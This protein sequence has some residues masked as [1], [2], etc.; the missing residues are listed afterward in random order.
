MLSTK[1]N[2][3][4]ENSAV[5]KTRSQ[6]PNYREESD[7]DLRMKSTKGKEV[8]ES[9]SVDTTKTGKK[10]GVDIED[11]DDEDMGEEETTGEEDPKDDGDS[12]ANF[13]SPVEQQPALAKLSRGRQHKPF[14]PAG[15]LTAP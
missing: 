9:S 12:D 6:N 4:L 3:V 8:Q 7:D 1:D 11:S 15:N 2:E 14:S 13:F 10:V 5:R